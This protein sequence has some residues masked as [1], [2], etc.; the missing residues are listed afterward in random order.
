MVDLMVGKL[1]PPAARDA[2]GAAAA[3]LP[4]A[5]APRLATLALVLRR[6]EEEIHARLWEAVRAGLVA[7]ARTA[8][9]RSSTTGSRR[10]PTR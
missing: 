2:G 4:R 9:T 5:T 7:R 8:P 1:Q 10:R 6:P 3:R